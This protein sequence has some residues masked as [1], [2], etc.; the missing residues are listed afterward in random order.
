MHYLS[1]FVAGI[2][3]QDYFATF[4]SNN[5]CDVICVVDEVCC[6]KVAIAKKIVFLI[7]DI[8]KGMVAI[9]ENHPYSIV[10]RQLWPVWPSLWQPKLL[11]VS[12]IQSYKK[13]QCFAQ[14]GN[15]DH[16]HGDKK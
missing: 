10:I 1:R 6:T 15:F 12:A 13:W 7:L 16:M 3:W 14:V 11:R 2:T 9:S 8:F 4:F 5:P